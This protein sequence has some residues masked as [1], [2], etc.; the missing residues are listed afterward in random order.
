MDPVAFVCF[1][2]ELLSYEGSVQQLAQLDLPTTVLVGANDFGLRGAADAMAAT[3][4]GAHLTVIEDAAHSPQVE[5]RDGWLKA[6]GDH[7]D[8][9]ATQT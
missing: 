3:I 8:R 6:V 9:L 2:E 4:P 7:F 5:N 1:G